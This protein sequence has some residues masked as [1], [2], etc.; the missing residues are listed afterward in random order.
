MILNVIPRHSVPVVPNSL[1][2]QVCYNVQF[3]RLILDNSDP[4]IQPQY[5]ASSV[6]GDDSDDKG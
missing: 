3:E 2:L 5:D 4:V 1:V 6:S